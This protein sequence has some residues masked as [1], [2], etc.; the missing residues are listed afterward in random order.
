M[1]GRWIARRYRL[2]RA[3]TSYWVLDL[4]YIETAILTDL[5]RLDASD[6]EQARYLVSSHKQNNDDSGDDMILYQK[7]I[8][9]T[10]NSL[11]DEFDDMYQ[12][13]PIESS[14][15]VFRVDL[16]NAGLTTED[17]GLIED[18][19]EINIVSQ[20]TLGQLIRGL[21]G[22]NKPWFHFDNFTDIAH[23]ADVYYSIT[24]TPAT[25]GGLL[26]KLGIDVNDQF[27]DFDA[28]FAGGNG[29]PISI[30]KE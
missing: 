29:S 25:L 12:V 24:D 18:T 14:R 30:Q 2:S 16:D 7:G 1:E 3:G 19:D 17:W 11:N 8:N 13:T 15:T 6:R 26:N 9:K 27:E 20:T 22:A 4:D 5:S 23:D 28:L 21:T 10:L